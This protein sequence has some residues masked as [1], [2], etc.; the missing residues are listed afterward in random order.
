MRLLIPFERLHDAAAVVILI[1]SWGR[2][3]RIIADR[4]SRAGQRRAAQF[5]SQGVGMLRPGSRCALTVS[6]GSGIARL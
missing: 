1:E 2:H 4:V 3:A 5:A 6:N